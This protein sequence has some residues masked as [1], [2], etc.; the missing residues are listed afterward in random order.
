MSRTYDMLQ[1]RVT[2]GMPL[3]ILET[4]PWPETL[5]EFITSADE[6]RPRIYVMGRIVD[7]DSAFYPRA[8]R[9][10]E[11]RFPACEV[12]PARG[13]WPSTPAWLTGWPSFAATVGL[14]IVVTGP[15]DVIGRG[16]WR[17]VEDL[18]AWKIPML[19]LKCGVSRVTP[20]PAPVVRQLPGDDWNS[21]ATVERAR[22][23]AAVVTP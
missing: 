15:G 20:V 4:T 13:L 5:E 3:A 9:W 7:Y 21:W 22:V 8:V 11:Q 6:E 12:V 23:P 17:E 16:V 14:G 1:G 19:W 18:T 2:F 10:T